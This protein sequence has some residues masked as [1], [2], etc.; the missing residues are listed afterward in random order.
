MGLST[1]IG[2]FIGAL[3]ALVVFDYILERDFQDSIELM[4]W[5][6]ACTFRNGF[7][8]DQDNGRFCVFEIGD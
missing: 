8:S 3:V 5:D 4:G 1:L 2:L 6:W 7:I